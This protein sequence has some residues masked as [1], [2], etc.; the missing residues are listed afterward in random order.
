MTAA[1]VVLRPMANPLPLGFLALAGGTFTVSGLQL[2]WVETAESASVGLIL[3]AFV[4]PLQLVASVLGF[5]ARDPATGTGMA[6]L[7]G[8]WGS[9]ALVTITGAPGATSDAMGLLLLV[10]A[11]AMGMCCAVAAPV[12]VVP[13]LVLATTTLRFAVTG[14]YELT[15]SG[16]WK[17]LAGWVGVALAAVA[18]YAALALLLEDGRRATV[19]PVGRRG[20]ARAAMDHAPQ[21]AV[22]RVWRE[23]GVRDQ[24]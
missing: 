4:V 10:S 18:G 23:A 5:L 9:L 1:R 12:K 15:G 3:L 22:A 6:I 11:T 7:A 21:D 19:L 17:D 13:A 14:V 20:A 24:L 16:G 2:G 8:T